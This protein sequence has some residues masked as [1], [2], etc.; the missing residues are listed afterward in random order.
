MASLPKRVVFSGRPIKMVLAL[1]TVLTNVPRRPG[2]MC[3]TFTAAHAS[4]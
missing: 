1:T 4:K 2:R 3:S